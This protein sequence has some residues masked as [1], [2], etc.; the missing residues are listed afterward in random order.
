MTSFF[1]GESVLDQEIL[2][3]VIRRFLLKPR[4]NVDLAD[5]DHHE[6]LQENEP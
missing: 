2:G 6:K 3:L 5:Q 4:L 1:F